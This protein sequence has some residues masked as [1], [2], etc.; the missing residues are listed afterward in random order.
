MFCRTLF[1]ILAVLVCSVMPK[2][3][4]G[5]VTEQ[6]TYDGKVYTLQ[7]N[8]LP[9]SYASDLWECYAGAGF[10]IV[11]A[12]YATGLFPAPGNPNT[13]IGLVTFLGWQSDTS[14]SQSMVTHATTGSSNQAG[15]YYPEPHWAI[16]DAVSKSS[17]EDVY[18]AAQS[19]VRWRVDEGPYEGE[20]WDQ[21]VLDDSSIYSPTGGGA[22]YDVGG[23]YGLLIQ[24]YLVTDVQDE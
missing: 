16:G 5:Q 9:G 3:S 21:N 13:Y 14:G 15:E 20:I 23:M 1:S 7:E 12:D 10:G 22:F 11:R 17:F 18:M 2:V 19:I 6:Y 4:S 8:G 24:D